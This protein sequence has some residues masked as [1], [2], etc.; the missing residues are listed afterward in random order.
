MFNS[1]IL[2]IVIGVWKIIAKQG[3]R[4]VH[5]LPISVCRVNTCQGRQL[6]QRKDHDMSCPGESILKK[7][8]G[9]GKSRIK[10]V[11]RDYIKDKS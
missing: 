5:H 6:K 4:S 3:F 8:S 7:G 9:E 10:D 1:P 11:Q 2:N